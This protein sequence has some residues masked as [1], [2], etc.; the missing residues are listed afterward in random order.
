VRAAIYTRVSSD[1]NGRGRS[2]GEQEADC[3]AVAEREGWDVVRVFCDNDRSAS[4]YSKKARP[5]YSELSAFVA[6]GSCEVLVTWEASRFQRDLEDYVRLRELCRSENVL[7]SYSGRTYD[8]SRTDDRMT[9]GLDA[10]LAERESDV[11]RDRILRTVRANAAKGRPHGRIP[12]GYERQ[13]NPATGELVAQVV[14]ESEASLIR[15]AAARF[16]AGEVPYK[17]AKDF[18][19]RGIPTSH[20][21]AWDTTRIRRLLTNPTYIGQR[22]HKGDL[23]AATWP[24]ILDEVSFRQCAARFADPDR[25]KFWGGSGFKYLLTYIARCGVCGAGVRAGAPRGLPTYICNDS[26]CIA[27]KIEPVD[28]LIT[29]LVIARLNRP[30]AATLFAPVQDEGLH[31]LLEEAAEKRARLDSFYEAAALGEITPTAL[32]R[33]EGR[34]LDEIATLE[35]RVQRVNVPTALYDLIG[36]ADRTW[37]TLEL[38][39]QREVIKTL[40]DIRL[41]KTVPGTRPLRPE[42]VEVT[43]KGSGEVEPTALPTAAGQ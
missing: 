24:P 9:T 10:L 25:K 16:L 29:K 1:P 43:W 6:S 40:M 12:F 31:Q 32:G 34:L 21:G 42:S 15:E 39:Q 33:V 23:T 11:A 8:L 20:S 18:N 5:A 19:R 28:E 35:R 41:L 37:P 27:R 26:F 7:W 22:G 30:D 4:R 36:Q 14:K 2:V 17:I 3:R 38:S 13:Y